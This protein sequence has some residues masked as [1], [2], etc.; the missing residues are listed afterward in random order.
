MY[1]PDI[2]R[3]S[4]TDRM[5]AEY[6][7]ESM[8][9][10]L[11]LEIWCAPSYLF[12]IGGRSHRSQI[13]SAGILKNNYWSGKEFVPIRIMEDMGNLKTQQDS[14]ARFTSNL[15]VVGFFSQQRV[16]KRLARRF[17]AATVP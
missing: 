7:R 16:K 9:P 6:W 15:W 17:L 12:R 4:P 2:E 14:C 1:M 11:G 8:L 13:N 3:K 10:P 5:A